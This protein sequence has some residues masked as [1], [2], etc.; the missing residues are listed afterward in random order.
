MLRPSRNYTANSVVVVTTCVSLA[1]LPLHIDLPHVRQGGGDR[2][3]RDD[4]KAVG[5]EDMSVP[6]S[7]VPCKPSLGEPVSHHPSRFWSRRVLDVLVQLLADAV[8]QR[9]GVQPHP[10]RPVVPEARL[11]AHRGDRPDDDLLLVEP[12]LGRVR[13]RV[14][15]GDVAQLVRVPTEDGRDGAEVPVRVLRRPERP[16][17]VRL[18]REGDAI[19]Q[20]ARTRWR[21]RNGFRCVEQMHLAVE[22]AES[23]VG[24]VVICSSR[25]VVFRLLPVRLVRDEPS[26]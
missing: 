2:T 9:L 11:R 7:V 8:D 5:A 6:H 19:G 16:L 3:Q 22:L 20:R 25:G 15:D 18:Q 13:E 14:R 24:L 17:D 4:R 12:A 21:G 10:V 23:S 1:L 26:R